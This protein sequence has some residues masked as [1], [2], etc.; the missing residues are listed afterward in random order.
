VLSLRQR[1]IG[2]GA[3]GCSVSL[4]APSEDRTHAQIE[5]TLGVGFAS[6]ALDA[7]LLRGAQERVN[8]ASKVVAVNDIEQKVQ[9][10]NQWFRSQAEEAGLD[11][12]NDLMDDG[13]AG[14]DNHDRHRLHE[15][16]KAEKRLRELLSQPLQTQRFG[17]FLTT[18]FI[19]GSRGK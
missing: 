14:G 15:A 1:G 5:R 16:R 18:S 7:R 2:N 9:K 8:Y 6:V 17:K 10:N 11:L 3:V 13:L 19:A 12:D 4:V